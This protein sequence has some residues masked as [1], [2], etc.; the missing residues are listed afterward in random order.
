VI[1]RPAK[2]KEKKKIWIANP[3][4]PNQ[5]FV[6][7]KWIPMTLWKQHRQKGTGARVR[8]ASHVI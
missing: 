3:K 8:T 2:Q 7:A 4:C 1:P 5:R 6:W